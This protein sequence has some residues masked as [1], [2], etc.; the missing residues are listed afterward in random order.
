MKVWLKKI[1]MFASI[2]LLTLSLF[3]FVDWLATE[4]RDPPATNPMRIAS[5]TFHHGLTSMTPKQ[6]VEWG[7]IKYTMATNSLGC[8]DAEARVVDR[9]NRQRLLFLG[10]SFTEGVGV[11]FENT[12]VG[13]TA[14]A[15]SI[16]HPPIDVLNAAVSSYSPI[17]YLRRL[18][19]LLAQGLQLESLVVFIDIS[20]IEDETLYTFDAQGN[21]VW[22]KEGLETWEYE[23]EHIPRNRGF[24]QRIW[25][26]VRLHTTYTRLLRRWFRIWKWEHFGPGY[27]GWID[28]SRAK[29][30]FDAEAMR[31]YGKKGLALAT[32][33]MTQLVQLAHENGVKDISIAVYPWPDQI[34]HHDLPSIQEQHW[35]DW[36]R[37]Q[38]VGFIDLF[39]VF[40]NGDAPTEI[41]QK[42]FIKGDAHWN[43]TGHRLVADE[44]LRFWSQR[45][46]A[47]P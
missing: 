34:F 8:R 26:F 27:L 37:A 4:L 25:R 32:E 38:K 6:E 15:L 23:V 18:K 9:A 39:P 22:D 41:T 28:L 19:D 36:A 21:V 10:D 31:E 44:F 14:A 43:E 20:D 1:V 5:P 40:I 33:H 3:I 13:L 16:R 12:F 2:S 17:I 45:Q 11:N 42:Y 47:G 7:P 29:W 30:T 24:A 46:Q 35:R